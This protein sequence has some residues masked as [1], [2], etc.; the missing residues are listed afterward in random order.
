MNMLT[1]KLRSALA[2]AATIMLLTAAH[3]Q[4]PRLVAEEMM[5]KSSDPGIEI[6]VRNRRPADMAAFRPDAGRT[7]L[8]DVCCCP[9]VPRDICGRLR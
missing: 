5:V 2:A 3:A 6:Y 4:S 7:T 1:G 8:R 9:G